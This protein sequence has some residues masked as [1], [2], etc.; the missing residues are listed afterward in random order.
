MGAIIGILVLALIGNAMASAEDKAASKIWV[1]QH[2][3][4]WA[5]RI[6]ILFGAWVAACESGWV[7]RLTH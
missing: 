4:P 7:A 3:E 5:W 1:K 2:L 6:L